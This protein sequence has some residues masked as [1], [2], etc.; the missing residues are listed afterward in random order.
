MVFHVK[1]CRLLHFIKPL[2]IKGA[3]FELPTSASHPVL[4]ISKLEDSAGHLGEEL[5]EPFFF[6]RKKKFKSAKGTC[7]ISFSFFLFLE[8]VG[9]DLH[10]NLC[11]PAEGY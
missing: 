8:E 10:F 7:F 4:V 6:L 11:F 1:R 2:E 5:V 9:Q 3:R